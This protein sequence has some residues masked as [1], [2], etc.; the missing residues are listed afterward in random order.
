[1]NFHPTHIFSMLD[2]LLLYQIFNLGMLIEVKNLTNL[3]NIY[4]LLALYYIF[5]K[6]AQICSIWVTFS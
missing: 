6:A 5:F 3:P 1:M 4:L 2:F